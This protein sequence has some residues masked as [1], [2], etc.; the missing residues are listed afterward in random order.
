[1]IL[2]WIYADNPITPQPKR[3]PALPVVLLN[4]CPPTPKSSISAWTT[5]V[6][7]TILLAPFNEINLSDKLILAIPSE[8]ASIFP[9]SPTWRTAASGAPCSTFVGLKWGPADVQPFVLS[10]NSWIWKPCNPGASPFISPVTVT[11]PLPSYKINKTIIIIDYEL[12][13][14]RMFYAKINLIT[15]IKIQNK[16][17]NIYEYVWHL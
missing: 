13:V 17:F 8:P 1:M 10:P 7:P 3:A 11:G 9:K 16:S 6:R 4:S 15:E 14:S 12:F 2:L 5:T